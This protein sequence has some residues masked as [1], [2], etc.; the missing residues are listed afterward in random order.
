MITLGTMTLGIMTHCTLTLG[1]QI[2]TSAWHN[3]IMKLAIMTL[4]IM[5]LGI[6]TLGIF[7]LA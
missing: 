2:D 1:W 5:T 3:G 6:M 4:G 7:H